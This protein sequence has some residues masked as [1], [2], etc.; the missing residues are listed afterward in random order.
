MFLLV[1]VSLTVGLIVACGGAEPASV[2]EVHCTEVEP[3]P[4]AEGIARQFDVSYEEV[5]VWFCGGHSFDDIL[6]ALQT[7]EL[8][9]RPAGELLVMKEDSSWDELWETLGLVS[10]PTE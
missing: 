6:L 10:Q 4:V 3:H 7:A 8:V 1:V 2:E 5:M 9:D